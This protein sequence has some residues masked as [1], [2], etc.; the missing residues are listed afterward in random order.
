MLNVIER[1]IGRY[2]VWRRSTPLRNPLNVPALILVLS[3]AQA[4]Y[5][6][7]TSHSL[8]WSGAILL[9]GDI[10]FLIL[11]LRSSPLAWLVLPF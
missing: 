8:S 4:V 10:T 3:I 5:R 7:A 6:L 2:E 1:F 9:V 11:Y